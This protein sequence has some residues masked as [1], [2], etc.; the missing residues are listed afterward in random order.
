MEKYIPPVY[1]TAEDEETKLINK[2]FE[3]LKNEESDIIIILGENHLKG[4]KHMPNYFKI[5]ENG[6]IKPVI[7]TGCTIEGEGKDGIGNAA[8]QHIAKV[9]N[10][11]V[12]NVKEISQ[13]EFNEIKIK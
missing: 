6:K 5:K 12:E 11:S 9:L 3:E 1:P 13:E 2:R 8:E 10:I 4:G 7:L